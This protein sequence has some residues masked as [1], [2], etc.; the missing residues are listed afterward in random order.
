[1]PKNLT[2]LP[3]A[4]A[5]ASSGIGAATALACARA[6]M[7]VVLGARRMDKLESVANRIADAGGRAVTIRC[8][9]TDPDECEALVQRTVD[10]FGSIYAVFANA[11]YGFEGSVLDTPEADQRAMFETNFWGTLNVI[12]PASERMIDAKRGHI[13][14]CSSCLS[15]IGIPLYAH[16]CATKACQ[17]LYGRALRIELAPK[18]ITVSTVHPIGTKTEFFDKAEERNPD[19]KLVD[20]ASD[21]FLQP[22]ERVANAIVRCMR[23]PRSEVWTSPLRY[24]L[25]LAGLAPT[26]RDAL[27]MR[28]VR[29]QAERASR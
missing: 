15:K 13:L 14:I 16:Y 24:A 26:M 18:G 23:K 20:R 2:G 8:D 7:P 11:G 3:I 12:R 22:P 17:D 10:E 27:L 5:G 25:A 6:G 28:G 29:K 9:V 1:M 21:R 4:I 19:A